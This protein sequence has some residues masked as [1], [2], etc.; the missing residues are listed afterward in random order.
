MASPKS[1]PKDAQMMA[2]ILKGMGI[3][4]YE[5]RVINQMLEVASWY[6][7]TILDDAKF[8]QV[9]LR[10]LLLTQIMFFHLSSPKRFFLLDIARQRNQTPLPLIKPY[11]GPRLPPDRYCLTAPNYRLKSLQKKKVST[12][13]GRMTVPQLS[14]GS[15]TSRP[16]T[17]MLGTPTPQAMSVST[18]VGTPVSLT[19]QR[20][21]AQM[22]TSQSPAV[23]ASI[24]AAS[25]VQNVLIN[26]SLIGSQILFLPL[27]W[28]HHKILPT[29]HQMH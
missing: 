4:E 16:S 8:I 1:M 12:S 23:K 27:T 3:P 17:P 2:Q 22:P 6:V 13:I 26:L 10:K 15:V 7:T 21:T 25:A 29:K 18:K 24:P 9:M 11:L 14:V 20:F 5:P 19:G 28:C